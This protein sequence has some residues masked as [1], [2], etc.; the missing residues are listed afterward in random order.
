MTEPPTPKEGTENSE[1]YIWVQELLTQDGKQWN[2]TIVQQLFETD[3]AHLILNT[4]IPIVAEGKL[5]W[6]LTRNGNFTLKSA[7]KKLHEI[8]LGDTEVSVNIQNTEI[9][10]KELWDIKIWPRVQHFWWKCLANILPTNERLSISC[11]YISKTFPLFNQ[12][13][14]GVMHVLFTCPFSRAVWMIIPGGSSVLTW[15]LTDT[16]SI[17]ESWMQSAQQ[18]SSQSKWLH[19]AMIVAWTIWNERCEVRFQHKQANPQTTARRAISFASY[20]KSLYAKQEPNNFVVHYNTS[21]RHWKPPA[22]HFIII[23]C[24]ASYDIHT[25]LTGISLILR[26][27]AEQWRG[28]SAKC[29]AGV[30]DSEQAECLA[31][32]EAVKWSK[33]LQHT[34][35]VLETDLK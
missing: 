17:F 26:D 33:E 11:R 8:S 19:L 15:V 18:D 16:N 4:R 35:V 21:S 13:D 7:Y 6:N 30:K 34:H 23:N 29:Y 25:G 31:F 32:F 3:T 14:E 2:V 1:D 20:I 28:S 5:V 9:L 12:H 27:F 10:W 24:D 22:P